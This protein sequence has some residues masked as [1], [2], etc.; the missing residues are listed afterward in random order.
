MPSAMEGVVADPVDSA[1]VG[2]AVERVE[3][4]VVEESAPRPCGVCHIRLRR[5]QR[6]VA[7]V[8]CGMTVHKKCC[9]LSRW[10]LEQGESW[11]CSVCGRAQRR[12]SESERELMLPPTSEP[13]P[14]GKCDVCRRARR[15]G[16]GICCS[17][18]GRVIHVK[19]AGLGTRGRAEAVDR[20]AWECDACS[21][22]RR[23]KEGDEGREGV[24]TGVRR[25]GGSQSITVMQWNCDHLSSKIPEL[26]VWLER[27][28]VDVAVVQETKLRAEDGEVRVRGYEMVRRDR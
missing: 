16:Q 13:L 14:A 12:V 23:E 25:E 19:C 6:G 10:A 26:E 17:V 7:C 22:Q 8:D 1:V 5:G 18:C 11:R 9:S 20:S 15:R 4:A 21:R 24:L 3:D 28:D 27:N 2:A